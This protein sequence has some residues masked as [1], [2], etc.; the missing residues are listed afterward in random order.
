MSLPYLKD[1]I[2]CKNEKNLKKYENF[3][4]T[5]PQV[6]NTIYFFFSLLIQDIILIYYERKQIPV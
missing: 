2:I 6:F 4:Y 3:P 5:P 1:P